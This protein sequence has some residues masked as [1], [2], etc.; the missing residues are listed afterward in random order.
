MSSSKYKIPFIKTIEAFFA[1]YKLGKP[2]HADVMCMRL[3]DQPDE[4]LIHMPAYKAGF[5][6]IIHF[7]KPGLQF[8]AGEKKHDISSNCICFTYPGK[9]ESWKRLNKLYGTVIYFSSEFLGLQALGKDIEKEYPFFKE[10]A[11][12]VLLLTD[13]ESEEI[14]RIAD[15]M[16]AEMHADA[17]D[18]IDLIKNELPLYLFKI[19]RLYNKKISSLSIEEKAYKGLL[20]RFKKELD[21]YI[22]E[23]LSGKKAITPTV[24]LIAKR[25][26]INSNYL[27]SVIKEVTGKTASEF[28]QEKILLHAKLYLLHSN[29]GVAEIAYMLGFENVSYFNRL[30]KKSVDMTPTAYREAY[31]EK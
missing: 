1:A 30:F 8:K 10:E 27:N 23:L 5:F 7:T 19:K 18:K 12:L 25:L 6:R 14:K 21:A 29:L 26:F 20:Q 31:I 3:E 16:I 9:T 28:I 24:S 11:E 15:E 4:K 2:L 13:E 17:I 22:Q